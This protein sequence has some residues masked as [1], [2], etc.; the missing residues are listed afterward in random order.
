MN[1]ERIFCKKCVLHDK[2]PNVFINDEGICNECVS[3]KNDTIIDSKIK[4]DLKKRVEKLFEK[5]KSENHIYDIMVLYSGGKDSTLLLKMLKEKY[6]LK[7]LA[8]QI[9]HPLV[10]ENA[11]INTEKTADII[12]VD[13]IKIF[14]DKNIYKKFMRE[15]IINSDKYNIGENGC[16]ICSFLFRWTG[17]RIAMQMDIPII[18]DGFDKSQGSNIYRFADLINKNAQKGILPYGKMHDVFNEIIGDDPRLGIYRFNQKDREK[19]VFPT[20]VSPFTFMDY[21]YREYEEE[22]C[23]IGINTSSIA[24]LNNMCKAIH[25]FDLIS[26]KKYDCHSFIRNWANGLRAGYPTLAQAELNRNKQKHN[27]TRK[28][29]IDIMEEYK[30]I[31]FYIAKTDDDD[32]CIRKKAYDMSPNVRKILSQESYEKI[33]NNIMVNMRK[34]IVFFEIDIDK[35]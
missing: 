14:Q 23:N 11:K 4:Q 35:I 9:V 18:A 34:M 32:E 21:D 7:V 24:R 20:Y 15:A 28:E 12:G 19:Y 16:G 27:S 22:I 1:S 13:L 10:G 5:V 6:K 3:Y 17:F 30:N 2:V 29:L 8:L 31:L 26:F 25:L 33:L